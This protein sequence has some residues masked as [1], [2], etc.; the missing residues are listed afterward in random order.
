MLDFSILQN[1]GLLHTSATAN[2]C[3]GA[4]GHVGTQLGGG[5]DMCAGVNE[6]GRDDVGRGSGE[7]LGSV[8]PG[9]LQ[10]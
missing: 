7:L 10:V 1:D 3:A 4:D 2:G 6:D 9:L 5:I 8:L